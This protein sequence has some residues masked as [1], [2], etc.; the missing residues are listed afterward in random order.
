MALS[1]LVTARWSSDKLVRLTNPDAPASAVDSA[2][3]AAACADA[4]AEFELLVGV[5][6]DS[7]DAFHASAACD[8]VAWVLM[9][10]GGTVQGDSLEAAE[11]RF[12]DAAER[13]ALTRGGRARIA[14]TT[15]SLLTPSE[16]V[17]EGREV[18]PDFDR[19]NMG[20]FLRPPGGSP[21]LDE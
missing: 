7:T 11:K 8:A 4:A 12:F 20:I 19:G 16:E 5:P 6:F 21:G 15:N 3:L 14:P 13:L 10:N 2:R 18:R 1:D 17:P 9:K